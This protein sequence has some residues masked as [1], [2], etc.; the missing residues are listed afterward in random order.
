MKALQL[1]VSACLLSARA[2]YW[3]LKSTLLF[4]PLSTL[5]NQLQKVKFK[6]AYVDL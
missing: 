5:L 6:E 3:L 2:S 1:P 4:S